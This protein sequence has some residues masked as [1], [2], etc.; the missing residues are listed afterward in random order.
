MRGLNRCKAP[1]PL[2]PT[3]SPEYRGEGVIII[4]IASQGSR[5]YAAT[6]GCVTLPFQGRRQG[7]HDY[8]ATEPGFRG[9][10]SRG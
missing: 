1:D 4:R 8:A 3:L 2:T 9:Y 6:L 5:E 10:F 7:S